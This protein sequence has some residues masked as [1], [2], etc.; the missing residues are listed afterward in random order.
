MLNTTEVYTLVKMLHWTMQ[1][2]SYP[3]CPV[4]DENV[5]FQMEGE[6]KVVTSSFCSVLLSQCVHL[7]GSLSPQQLRQ[8][9][10]CNFIFFSELKSRSC[11]WGGHRQV[12]LL[13]L[14]IYFFTEVTDPRFPVFRAALHP[15]KMP[16]PVPSVPC[17][18]PG[19][20][21]SEFNWMPSVPA[22]WEFYV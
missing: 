14:L 13:S 7:S 6:D 15:L 9:S 1:V 3:A 17:Y 16:V 18:F 19:P 5:W 8:T 2:I 21:P 22:P 12:L 4:T 10:V 20:L 11:W